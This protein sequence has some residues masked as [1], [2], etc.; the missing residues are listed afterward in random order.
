MSTYLDYSSNIS[1]VFV[2][3]DGTEVITYEPESTNCNYSGPLMGGGDSTYVEESYCTNLALG[4]LGML[5][6]SGNDYSNTEWQD[7]NI[8]VYGSDVSDFLVHESNPGS[9]FTP[10]GWSI[11]TGAGDDQVSLIQMYGRAY[12]GNVDTVDLGAGDDIAV[13]ADWS[14]Y[15]VWDGGSALT[16]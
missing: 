10:A 11:E 5:R 2:R 7:L 16:G 12:H 8:S 14:V 15:D 4:R 9:E 3:T 13:V 1:H 6:P